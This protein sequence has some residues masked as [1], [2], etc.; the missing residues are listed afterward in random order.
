MQVS[1]IIPLYEYFTN[2]LLTWFLLAALFDHLLY[3][4]RDAESN[5]NPVAII[6]GIHYVIIDREAEAEANPN[7][8][9][10]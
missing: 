6:D 7:A 10:S 8:G 1:Q 2:T 3:I 4:K 5:P 9:T